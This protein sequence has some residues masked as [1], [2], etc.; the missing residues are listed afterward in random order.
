MAKALIPRH[1]KGG[2]EHTGAL[3]EPSTE[4]DAP[5]QPNV[6]FPGAILASFELLAI[7]I[8]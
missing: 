6:A 5:L 7:S 3:G 2:L 1:Q 8:T 4:L